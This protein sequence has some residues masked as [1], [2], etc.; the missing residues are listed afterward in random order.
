MSTCLLFAVFITSHRASPYDAHFS[1][2][3]R[4]TSNVVM[5]TLPSAIEVILYKQ[6]T[7]L[8][9]VLIWLVHGCH[10]SWMLNQH[11]VT[12]TLTPSMWFTKPDIWSLNPCDLL[13]LGLF[14]RYLAQLITLGSPACIIM[15]VIDEQV[16]LGRRQTI[17]NHQGSYS[18]YNTRARVRQPLG[19]FDI[20]G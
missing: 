18:Y 12:D 4:V 5:I 10:L 7:I 8:R 15:M 17:S 6:D 19:S 16:P 1:I 3:S 20:N 14:Q 2:F 9:Q 13:L 11:R